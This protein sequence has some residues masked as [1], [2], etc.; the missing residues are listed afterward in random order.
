MSGGRHRSRAQLLT[1]YQSNPASASTASASSYMSACRSSSGW[2]TS[3]RRICL[4]E[5]RAGL[6]DQAVRRQVVRLLGDGGVERAPPVVE[7]LPRGAVDQVEAHLQSR[8][9]G[10]AHHQRDPLRVVGALQGGEH[11]RHGR[12]HA[13]GHPGESGGLQREQVVRVDRVRVGLGG[14]LGA[15][16]EPPG[17]HDAVEHVG[18]VAHRQQG[19]GA[20]AEEDGGHR[21]R[22]DRRALEHGAGLTDLRGWP[23]WRSRCVSPRAVLEPC[24]C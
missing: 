13:E 12:L 11:V 9:A 8:V 14:H 16:H 18:E 21:P 10:P 17:V 3:P 22:R 4:R 23:G 5:F 20:A 24:R 15:G 19:R 6:H 7:A 2:A 1:S